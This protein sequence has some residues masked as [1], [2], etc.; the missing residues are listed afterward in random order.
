[1][2]TVSIGAFIGVQPFSLALS[3]TVRIRSHSVRLKALNVRIIPHL[4]P[5]WRLTIEALK[6]VTLLS[7]T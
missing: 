6:K 1:M 7:L 3:L 2:D 5:T 4:P